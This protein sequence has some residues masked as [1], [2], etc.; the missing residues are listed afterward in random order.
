VYSLRLTPDGKYVVSAGNAPRNQ[1]YLA[2]WDL[3]DGKLIYGEELPLGPIYALAVAPN[4]K[5][6]AVASGPRGRQLQEANAYLLL[7]PEAPK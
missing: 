3:S 7:M 6:L 4:G 5:Q 1:G 2:V